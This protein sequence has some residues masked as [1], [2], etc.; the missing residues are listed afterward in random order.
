[1]RNIL[2]YNGWAFADKDGA[3]VT[4]AAEMDLTAASISVDSISAEVRC[5][6]PAIARFNVNAPMTYIHKRAP[7]YFADSAGRLFLTGAGQLFALSPDSRRRL[8]DYGVFQQK[9]FYLQSVTRVG[10]DHYLLYGLT[11]AGRLTRMPHAGGIYTGQRAGDV[12]ADI[13][14]DVPV[15]VKHNLADIRLYGWLPYVKPE[16]GSARDNLAQVL[17]ALGAYLGTD[18]NGVLRVQTYWDGMAAV[19]PGDRVYNDAS[20]PYAQAVT[21][22]TVA[23]HQYIPGK[24]D[25]TLFEG[26]ALEGD[27]I[28]FDEPAHSL[29]AAGFSILDRGA[30]WARLSAGTGTLTGKAYDH[31]TREIREAVTAAAEENAKTEEGCTLISLVN[32]RAVAERLA[33]Y[34]RCQETIQC[35]IVAQAERPGYV[36]GVYHPFDKRIVPACISNMDTTVS[37]VLKTELKALVGFQPPQYAESVGYDRQVMLTGA[38][39][40]E[41]PEGVTHIR[42]VLI[43]PGEGGASGLPGEQAAEQRTVSASGGIQIRKLTKYYTDGGKGGK[44]GK[45]GK[46]GRIYQFELDVQPGQRF[47][48]SCGSGGSGGAYNAE[49]SA[50][51]SA[52]TATTFGSYSSAR[53]SSSSSGFLD[54]VSST[55]YGG[56]GDTGVD[57]GQGCGS[58]GESN[59]VTPVAG[60]PVVYRGT[61]Y[62]PGSAAKT[63]HDSG[64]VSI[65]TYEWLQA[66]WTDGLGGGAAAGGN[67]HDGGANGSHSVRS[68][69][70]ASSATATG[71]T[72]GAGAD[73]TPPPAEARYGRGGTGGNGG[74]GAGSPGIA[75]VIHLANSD[76]TPSNPTLTVGTTRYGTPGKGSNGGKGG[77]GCV[78]LY[79]TVS[80]SFPGGAFMTEDGKFFLDGLG[81]LFVV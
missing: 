74:G 33:Y 8:T 62:Y 42:A 47:S 23:E 16:K 9:I 51:G 31:T 25:V 58:G 81:R 75:E 30:N 78:L 71:G 60:G 66:T 27:V 64:T 69:A 65:G 40:F 57:G 53:G 29:S 52:G 80:Q 77:P 37:S 13:C 5:A 44:A 73:A 46:G 18:L 22:V 6:D 56:D 67:G 4:M 7:T 55:V 11:P 34:Y 26:T 17:F 32:S 49:E 54:P 14:G 38:G 59:S 1:M 19:I 41:I 50:P 3:N 72:G 35:S 15:I 68:S 12:I 28:A 63:V 48:Y 10:P 39:T 70:I 79:F 36:V 20:V 24:E 45:G 21:S 76:V 43:G 2:L 61:T